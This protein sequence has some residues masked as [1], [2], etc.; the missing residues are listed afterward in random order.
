MSYLEWK[1]NQEL[2]GRSTFEKDQ[3]FRDDGLELDDDG[4]GDEKETVEEIYLW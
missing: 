1:L 3:K 2:K 4:W